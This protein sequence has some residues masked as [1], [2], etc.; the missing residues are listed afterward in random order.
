MQVGEEVVG[1]PWRLHI[2]HIKY[3][4]SYPVFLEISIFTHILLPSGAD[5][6][7]CTEFFDSKNETQ[8]NMKV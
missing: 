4:N 8:V 7:I 2:C 1:F 3:H 6:P 5:D